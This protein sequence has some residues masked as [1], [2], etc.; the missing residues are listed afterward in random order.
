MSAQRYA[1][2]PE[3]V[4]LEGD[5]EHHMVHT[6][7]IRLHVAVAGNPSNPL[8]LL[9]HGTFGGWFDYKEVI[10][11]LAAAGYHVAA[12]DMRGYGMSDKPPQTPGDEMRIATGDIA[13]VISSLGHS[14]AVLVGH[15]TGGTVAWACATHYPEKIHALVS[16]SA[17][18]PTDLRAAVRRRPWDFMP[19]I[20]R[21]TI[22]RLP[23]Q[24]LSRL[25]SLRAPTWRKSLE[26]DTTTKF[27]RTNAF[28]ETLELRLKAAD[29]G[30]AMPYIVHNSRLL[31]PRL[32]VSFQQ[33]ALVTAPTL[34]IHPKQSLWNPIVTLSRKR[35]DA[36][37]TE[38]SIDEAKNLPPI[39]QPERFLAHLANYFKTV[40]G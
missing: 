1:T 32:P 22:A 11:P 29:I 27:H 2:S 4:K 5:F 40:L 26:F 28:K 9:I 21:I 16:I 20:G 25:S 13:A 31:T 7:G 24:F 39:E 33:D 14:K 38:L 3:V 8:V 36:D 19:I 10:A 15:D 23:S 17:A 18:H 6:R 30:H 34:L 12:I 35:V 37:V